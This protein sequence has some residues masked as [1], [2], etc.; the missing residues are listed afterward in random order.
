MNTTLHNFNDIFSE[1]KYG[2]DFGYSPEW[3][4]EVEK[5][6]SFVKSLDE[7]WYESNKRRAKNAKQRDELLGEYKTM[8]FVG[9]ES[10]CRITQ[11]EPQG[12]A[13]AK[14]DFSFKDKGGDNWYVEVKS[15]SWRNEVSKEIDD[16]YL[17][18]LLSTLVVIETSQWP[19]CRVV[20]SC[21]QCSEVLPVDLE[22]L[23]RVKVEVKKT[24]CPDCKQN[25]W[26][27]SENERSNLKK[28]RLSQPQFINAE[29]RS[30]S[31]KDAVEDA[32][33]KSVQ[34]FEVNRNNLLVVAHNMFAGLGIGLLARMDG[35][36]S[37][38]KIIEKY[39][40][41]NLISCVCLVEV[42]LDEKG[43]RFHP[44]LVRI[45]KQPLF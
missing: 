19:K 1:N 38:K 24:I 12:R 32:V 25:I 29:G 40:V 18:S 4:Q 23:N 14:N 3:N 5:W 2:D 34:Q 20:V 17:D 42:R 28:K 30:F 26:R 13:K 44:V 15:P 21:P 8:Y 22:H 45:K 16:M 35:G 31:V 33:R 11:I 39:D 37:V 6:L 36:S 43:I 41:N 9:V 7:S 27:H 10:G